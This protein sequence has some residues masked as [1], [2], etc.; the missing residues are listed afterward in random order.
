MTRTRR[1]LALGL[2]LGLSPALLVG[3]WTPEKRLSRTP[4]SAN[5]L[6]IAASGCSVYVAWRDDTDFFWKVFLSRSRDSGTTWTTAKRVAAADENSI[7]DL[8]LAAQGRRVHLFWEQY[9]SEGSRLF[10]QRSMNRGRSWRPA[11]LLSDETLDSDAPTI[12][13]DDR[14]VY[15]A[16]RSALDSPEDPTGL[17]RRLRFAHSANRGRRFEQRWLT[18]T[19]VVAWGSHLAVSAGRLHFVFGR[20]ER[21]AEEW[22]SRVFHRHTDS[23]GLRW[24]KKHLVSNALGHP[25]D[26]SVEGDRVHL[27]LGAG[28]YKTAK[29]WY[30]RSDDGGR[31]WTAEHLLNH[32]SMDASGAVVAATGEYVNAAWIEDWSEWGP[33]RY[34]RSED[35]GQTWTE[36]A[37][38]VDLARSPAIATVPEGEAC[39]GDTHLVYSRYLDRSV[40]AR[41]EVFYRRAS[42]D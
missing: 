10:Y 40:N 27:V 13:T 41:M 2:F 4:G 8:A 39:A 15:V 22:R 18:G 14:H 29:S 33:L 19:P 35:G 9:R 20:S 17:E 7:I 32:G 24:S 21:L 37:R 6:A 31:S 3:D 42:P 12:A 28:G 30:R 1:L 36:T 25:T 23:R 5:H 38:V 16:W 26:I 11:Q 34:S